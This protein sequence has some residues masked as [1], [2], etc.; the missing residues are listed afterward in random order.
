MDKRI[1]II[2]AGPMGL[3][4][5]YQLVKEGYQPIVFEA[6]DRIGGMSAIFDFGGI[7]TE[8]YYHFHCTSD[9][10]FFNILKE[11][12]I[13]EQLHWKATK[14]GYWY[15][16]QLQEWGHPLALLRFRGLSLI[17][18]I[19]Y[20]LHAFLAT[21]RDNWKPLEKYDAVTWIEKWV[22][23]EAYEVLWSK[24]F[25]QKFYHYTYSLSAPWIWSRIRRIGRSRYNIFHEKLLVLH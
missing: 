5:A 21:K 11:L 6:D 10:A 4:V 18:K 7:E 1:A 13:E 12:E 8:R 17:S 15:N 19:R 24:L 20:G 9:D 14:M 3:A 25:S 22:G 16:N 23:K 2:G